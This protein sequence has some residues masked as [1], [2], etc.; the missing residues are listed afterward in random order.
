MLSMPRQK[1]NGNKAAGIEHANSKSI[2]ISLQNIDFNGA[3]LS[4]SL[5]RCFER[6]IGAFL[7][8]KALIKVC[9]KVIHFVV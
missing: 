7:L 6:I 9:Y 2:S 4:I 5:S 3:T 8:A 1:T